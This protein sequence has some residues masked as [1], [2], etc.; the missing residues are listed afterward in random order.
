[1]EGRGRAQS[2]RPRPEHWSRDHAVARFPGRPG[3]AR[4]RAKGGDG[5]GR[6]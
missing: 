6:G 2:D 5:A 1:M 4:L 3:H